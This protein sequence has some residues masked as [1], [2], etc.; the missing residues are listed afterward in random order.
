MNRIG[1]NGTFLDLFPASDYDPTEFERPCVTSDICICRTMNKQIQILLVKRL[2]EPF[3]GQWSIPGG[4]IDV[5]KYE[6]SEQAA[7]RKLKDKTGVKNVQL[8]QL[9]F[10]DNA[11][12]DPRWIVMS[13]VYFTLISAENS[14][15][16][17]IESG[18][19]SGELNW[20]N[21]RDLP[22]M[23]F[24]HKA[25]LSDLQEQLKKLMESQPIA[26]EFL[27]KY[28]SWS[29]LQNTYEVVLDRRLVVSNFRRKINHNYLLFSNGLSVNSPKGRPSKIMEYCGEKPKF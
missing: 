25:I 3:I 22:V 2:N 13:V 15:Q 7:H 8:R 5:K 20:F 24:D 19:H 27:P 12:R 14:N 21:L 17:D 4:F 23:A 28:F 29:E 9:G 16:A 1:I 10:Y 18:I 26:F 6:T 11:N